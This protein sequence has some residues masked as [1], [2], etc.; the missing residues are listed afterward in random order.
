MI[1]YL[2]SHIGGS[3]KIDN[4]RIPTKLT[5]DNGFLD[6]LRKRWKK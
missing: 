1:V 3:Y 6:S 2:T 4:E 5:T